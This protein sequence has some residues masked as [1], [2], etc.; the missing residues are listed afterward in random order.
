MVKTSARQAG[1]GTGIT[2]H[3]I[4][5]ACATHMLRNGAHPVEIQ[6]LLGHSSLKHL[7]QYLRISITDIRKMHRESKVSE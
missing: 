1:I 4:R 7:S 6:M 5:R 3:G 2:V